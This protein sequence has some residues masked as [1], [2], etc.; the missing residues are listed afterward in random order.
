MLVLGKP[1]RYKWP[2]KL[3]IPVDGGKFESAEFVAEFKRLPQSR[4]DQIREAA[5]A[6][7][8]TDAQLLDEVW[9]GW[10]KI[11]DPDGRPLDYNEPN[12]DLVLEITGARTALVNAWIESVEEGRRKNSPRPRGT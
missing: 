7:D 6:N 1:D 10:D 11:K 4:V 8:L 3:E 2:V 5:R 12:R 9:T